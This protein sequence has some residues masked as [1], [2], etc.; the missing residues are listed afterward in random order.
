MANA[1]SLIANSMVVAIVWTGEPIAC[2]T[3]K[4]LLATAHSVDTDSSSR[5]IERALFNGFSFAECSG[6]AWKTDTYSTNTV[7][8]VV[9]VMRAARLITRIAEPALITLAHAS[10]ADSVTRT[11]HWTR[12]LI[13]LVT[14]RSGPA[15]VTLTLSRTFV[16]RAAIHALLVRVSGAMRLFAPLAEER[17]VT[18]ALSDG[19]IA[20][21]VLVAVVFAEHLRT[22]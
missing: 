21:S 9:A 10:I 11:I 14:H 2:R 4:V 1:R 22:I 18:H 6:P 16:A 8:V 13:C 12:W 15:V 17:R 20:S 5:T 7:A 3:R 19:F